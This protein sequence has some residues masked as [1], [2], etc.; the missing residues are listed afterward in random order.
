MWSTLLTLSL[1]LSAAFSLV[2]C[3]QGEDAKKAS[4]SGKSYAL[5]ITPPPAGKVGQSF[6]ASVALKPLGEYKINMEYPLRLTVKGPKTV[7]PREVVMRAKDA[8]KMTKAEV[9]LV[10]KAKITVAGEH[11]FEAEFRFSVCTEKHCELKT[12]KL[13]WKVK[14][15]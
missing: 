15:Q 10:P 11:A 13:T 9:L 5:S 6:A 1:T 2:A 3:S 7:T 8:K 4:K 14:V 12:E